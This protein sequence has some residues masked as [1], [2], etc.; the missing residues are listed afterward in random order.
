MQLSSFYPVIMT[1]A[2][3][4]LATRDFYTQKLGFG[5]TYEADWYISLKR[6]GTPFP[7]EL[8]I[9]DHTHPTIPAG[10]GQP[11]AG[12]LLNFEVADVDAEYQRLVE[13]GG[14]Q[15]L[16]PLRDEVF[17]QRHFMISDPN[18]VLIDIITVI[19]PNAEE[20]AQYTEK[21]W[22]E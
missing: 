2:D 8:A 1:T 20:A 6:V 3:K 4:L 21:I 7:F 17:G 5:I 16:I 15:A 18:G 13:R 10:Q 9:L 11:V 22:E 12:L 14:M 19:P